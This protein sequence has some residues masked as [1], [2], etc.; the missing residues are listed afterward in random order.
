MSEAT[1]DNTDPFTSR[2]LPDGDQFSAIHRIERDESH[3]NPCG[4]RMS[5][6]V[7]GPGAPAVPK[8]PLPANVET[9]P[10]VDRTRTRRLPHSEK[11]YRPS[12]T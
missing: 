7:R 3:A 4:S 9:V 5:A 12:G 11:K 2:S 8:L 6:D 1:E 10:P